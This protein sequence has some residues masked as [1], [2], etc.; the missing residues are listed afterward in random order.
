MAE[1][2]KIAGASLAM[3]ILGAVLSVATFFV[4][5][6]YASGEFSITLVTG[7]ILMILSGFLF[8]LQATPIRVDY[9]TNLSE[10]NIRGPFFGMK[11]KY[12]DIAAVEY[13]EFL[14]GMPLI[15]LKSSEGILGGQFRSSEVGMCHVVGFSR[16]K[17]TKF[18]LMEIS[19]GKIVAFNLESEE[20]TEVAY[21]TIMSKAL[22]RR[23][24]IRK[25]G[26]R[27]N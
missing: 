14:P 27:N 25:K 24:T 22:I 7:L 6:S 20:E 11:I 26:A 1:P 15:A 18:I 23:T 12:S 3:F 19:D 10:F 13:R 8:L 5:G 17:G 2:Q 9:T 16:G 21:N 4:P